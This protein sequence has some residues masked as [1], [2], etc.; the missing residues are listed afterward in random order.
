MPK[1][2]Y[3]HREP[4]H[5]WQELRPL[6]KDL[7]QI[8]YEITQ[9]VLALLCPGLLDPHTTHWT[10]IPAGQLHRL[11]DMAGRPCFWRDDYQDHLVGLLAALLVSCGSSA[12][13][14]QAA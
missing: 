5:D 8:S 14:Q 6:L 4:T 11:S 9:G 7:A 3:Q 2:K 1:H 10:L 13:G 12:P